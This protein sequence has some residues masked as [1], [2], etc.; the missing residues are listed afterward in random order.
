MLRRAEIVRWMCTAAAAAARAASGDPASL[1]HQLQLGR[2][3]S[4]A[5]FP[6]AHP[7]PQVCLPSPLRLPRRI[8]WW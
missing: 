2:D 6:A 5:A 4:S 7:G 8:S 3:S 1:L